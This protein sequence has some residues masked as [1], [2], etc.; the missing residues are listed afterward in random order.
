MSSGKEIDDD[1][2][3]K[4]KNIFVDELMRR[5]RCS[6]TFEMASG[7]VMPLMTYPETDPVAAFYKKDRDEDLV[8]EKWNAE[9]DCE[10]LRKAMR[11][12]GKG[13]GGTLIFSAYVGS[14]PAS[15][16]HPPKNIRN[17]KHPKKYLK[18]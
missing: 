3:T 8:G 10:Y 6:A 2:K 17:F 13:P 15:A 5:F 18:F 1:I 12:L 7:T 4:M 11:G 16:L 14:E 9:A